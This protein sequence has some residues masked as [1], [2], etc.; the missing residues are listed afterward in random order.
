MPLT[1]VWLIA[2]LIAVSTRPVA[3]KLLFSLPS[4]NVAKVWERNSLLRFFGWQSFHF[5]SVSTYSNSTMAKTRFHVA[6]LWH[7]LH[8]LQSRPCLSFPISR[9]G[10]EENKVTET[11]TNLGRIIFYYLSFPILFLSNQ[12]I[13]LFS[14]LMISIAHDLFYTIHHDNKGVLTGHMLGVR[15]GHSD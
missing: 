12:F 15:I 5:Y 14:Y 8:C 6:F 1:V 3:S 13:P 10:F 7:L 4:D 2:I 9:I 11:E